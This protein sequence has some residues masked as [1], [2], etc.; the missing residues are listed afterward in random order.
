MTKVVILQLN[1]MYWLI[2]SEEVGKGRSKRMYQG[3]RLIPA[4]SH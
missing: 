3:K 4:L 2:G 1:G